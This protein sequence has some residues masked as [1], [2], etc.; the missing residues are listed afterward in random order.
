MAEFYPSKKEAREAA[1]LRARSQLEKGFGVYFEESDPTGFIV[2][3]MTP[4]PQEDYF[5]WREE[6]CLKDK[7]PGE[8]IDELQKEIDCL[9]RVL[10][11]RDERIEKMQQQLEKLHKQRNEVIVENVK[12]ETAIKAGVKSLKRQDVFH[13]AKDEQIEKLQKQVAGSQTESFLKGL[14]QSI[15]EKDNA[16]KQL[17]NR[18]DV[19][20]KKNDLLSYDLSQALKKLEKLQQ[21]CCDSTCPH[22][23][24]F[25]DEIDRII[26]EKGEQIRD[27]QKRLIREDKHRAELQNNCELAYRKLNDAEKTIQSQ[28]KTIEDL[29]TGKICKGDES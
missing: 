16:I 2:K 7:D 28:K 18:L 20:H 27:L 22:E 17:R 9:A 10:R 4:A 1:L 29:W 6:D 3:C 25:Q 21:Q 26:A 5:L 11:E 13:E 8:I 23:I 12:L 15:V 14:N 24:K 19:A